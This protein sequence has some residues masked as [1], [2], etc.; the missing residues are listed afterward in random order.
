VLPS[1]G[2]LIYTVISY[3]VFRGK[4]ARQRCTEVPAA[5]RIKSNFRFLKPNL[6]MGEPAFPAV[7]V[8]RRARPIASP[9]LFARS[10]FFGF[11][12][13]FLIP[14]LRDTFLSY[15]LIAVASRLLQ[16]WSGYT[17]ALILA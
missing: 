14:S 1:D 2:P 9:Q 7:T 4:S 16:T 12:K 5:V 3:R 17:Q 8:Q 15:P 11:R 6:K 10:T 13:R